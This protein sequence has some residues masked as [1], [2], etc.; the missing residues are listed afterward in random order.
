MSVVYLSDLRPD[1]RPFE[2]DCGKI[3]GYRFRGNL[4]TEL[5]AGRIEARTAID[6][7]ED[8]L[9]I[10]E[11]EEMIVSCG[12]ARTNPSRISITG[13]RRMYR[14]ARKALPWERAAP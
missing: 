11:M 9:M 7:L 8:M 14:S 5:D 13:G 3:H 4:R 2:M 12:P 10:R 1:F 6:L